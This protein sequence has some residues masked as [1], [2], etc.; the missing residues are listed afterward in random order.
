MAKLAD[1]FKTL[2]QIPEGAENP[3]GLVKLRISKLGHGTVCS[4]CNGNGNYGGYGTCFK[5]GGNGLGSFK[6]T[7]ALYEEVAKAVE[8]GK[9]TKYFEEVK[10]RRVLTKAADE[11]FKLMNVNELSKDYSTNY[12]KDRFNMNPILVK[13]R[14]EQCE[15]QRKF[16]KKHFAYCQK[17][18]RA[19]EA[20]RIEM[21]AQLMDYYEMA[22]GE[23]IRV[24]KEWSD[25][26]Q[27]MT[28]GYFENGGE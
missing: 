9:L 27:L 23:L 7:K 15:I 22:K 5:C 10:M 21:N 26:K 12:N 25:L 24:K 13:L 28:S 3:D 8:D 17:Y 6:L 19:T 20:E 4:R 2:L 11:I 18:K 1:K 16:E 14:H